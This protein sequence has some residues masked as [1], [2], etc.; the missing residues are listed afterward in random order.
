M[1]KILSSLVGLVIILA[2]G[3]GVLAAQTGR[4]RQVSTPP[5]PQPPEKD[6]QKI[7]F[8]RYVPGFGK[9]KPCDYDGVCDEDEKGWCSDCKGGEEPTPTPDKSACYDFLQGSKPRW[10]WVEDY[11]YDV[12]LGEVSSWATSIW[13]K[14]VS[15]EIF[16]SGQPGSYQWGVYDSINSVSYGDYE[17]EG[18]LAVTAIWFRGKDIFEYDIMLDTDYFPEGEFDLG[19]V[20][21]HEFGHAAGLGDLYNVVCQ[22]EVMYGYLAPGETREILGPGD[23]IGIRT[24]YQ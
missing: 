12:Y 2:A 19:T 8:I 7:V 23:T 21:L 3:S 18:V 11:Y 15:R 16:G 5:F 20:T 22:D 10:N 13:E 14:P 6:L 24:L 17:E 9:E 1:K 4:G